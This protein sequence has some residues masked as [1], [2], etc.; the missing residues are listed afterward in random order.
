MSIMENSYHSILN[1]EYATKFIFD[2]AMRTI[3]LKTNT[4]EWLLLQAYYKI[5]P[6]NFII[7]SHLHTT[8]EDHYPHISVKINFSNASIQTLHLYCMIS[9][10]GHV[11]LKKITCLSSS[12]E[13]VPFTI[14]EY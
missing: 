5:E 7:T 10:N 3:A 12:C 13:R 8:E 6:Y 9:G 11:F 2:F 1:L 4:Q 14:A